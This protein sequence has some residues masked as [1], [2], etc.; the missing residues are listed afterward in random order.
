VFLFLKKKHEHRE[1][2]EM[3]YSDCIV[4]ISALLV[5]GLCLLCYRRWVSPQLYYHHYS[6]VI[7][8]FIDLTSL[9]LATLGMFLGGKLGSFLVFLLGGTGYVNYPR[10]L[11]RWIK[12]AK[13][14]RIVNEKIKKIIFRKE[15]IFLSLS[16]MVIIGI[17]VVRKCGLNRAASVYYGIPLGV[18]VNYL[19]TFLC[20]NKLST[21]LEKAKNVE[22]DQQ[23]IKD[24]IKSHDRSLTKYSL[25]AL[26]TTLALML[27][28]SLAD[29]I[30]LF[31]PIIDG[32]I[33]WPASM[34]GFLIGVYTYKF[35]FRV[36]EF[37]RQ[38]GQSQSV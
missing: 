7:K 19:L 25:T 10:N 8:L 12:Y 23:A 27:I 22:V 37:C 9:P 6:L 17:Y 14:M 13:R 18:F 26:T 15:L 3:S 36:G 35:F 29:Q 24:A 32:F 11:V 33:S 21:E 2:I 16:Y 5:S 1:L 30:N 28:L 4:G 31:N 20:V 34:A 38:R